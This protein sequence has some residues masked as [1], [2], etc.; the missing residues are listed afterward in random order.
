MSFAHDDSGQI[1]DGLKKMV[2]YL[3]ALDI[4]RYQSLIINYAKWILDQNVKL[5]IKACYFRF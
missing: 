2:E 3:Q 1:T 5:G 4:N